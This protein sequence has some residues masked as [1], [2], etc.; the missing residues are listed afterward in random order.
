MT[1]AGKP[2]KTRTRHGVRPHSQWRAV[3]QAKL[4][5]PAAS[6]AG[7]ILELICGPAN[8]C[9]PDGSFG[10]AAGEIAAKLGIHKSEASRQLRMLHA[11]DFVERFRRGRNIMY[12]STVTGCAAY[13]ELFQPLPPEVTLLS[14]EYTLVPQIQE[15]FWALS[16][17]VLGVGGGG[18][19]T[20]LKIGT[21]EECE[22]VFESIRQAVIDG[23]QLVIHDTLA[24]DIERALNS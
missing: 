20:K 7:R 16:R 6:H 5:F 1:D 21:R 4:D 22:Q 17:S 9:R 23:E 19:F 3:V 2:T 11:K 10:L 15:D 8:A 14:V 18:G 13:E 12:R 24:A